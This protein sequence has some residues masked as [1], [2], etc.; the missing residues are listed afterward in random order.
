MIA[1]RALEDVAAG[2]GREQVGDLRL[3]GVREGGIR[4]DEDGRRVGAV[5][6]LGDQVRGHAAGIGR[7]R[8][9]DH[10]LRRAGGQVDAD[11]AADLDLRGRDP[12]VARADDAVHR[13]DPG[14]GQAVGQ[15][16]D[17]LGATG[18]DERVDLEQA[19]RPEEDRVRRPVAVGRRGD[20]DAL[21]AGDPC[22]DDGHHQGRRVRGGPA[23]DIGADRGQ[24]GPAAFDLDAG[25]HRRRASTRAAGSRRSGGRGRS[26]G[27]GRAGRPAS[28]RPWRRGGR[29]GRGR[30]GR[31][32]ARHRRARSPRGRP[33]RR[34]CGPRPGSPG[35]RRGSPRRV[36]RRGG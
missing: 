5:L 6:G 2:R 17:G 34:A 22:R 7:R 26:P 33:R 10:P 30:A 20:H 31:H 12:G 23:R 8:G 9:E 13:R 3:D 1:Q 28:G 21:D 36:R 32:A 14:L 27:R 35:R 19:G 15:G 25:D 18:H 24:R 29:R 11:I 4:R 16:A